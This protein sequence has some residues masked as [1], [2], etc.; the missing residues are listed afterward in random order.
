MADYQTMYLHLFNHVTDAVSALERMNVGQAKE[1][2]MDA[3]KEAEL[4]YIDG[5]PASKT[6]WLPK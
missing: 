1:V 6:K 3:Q 5:N 4:L 2:L